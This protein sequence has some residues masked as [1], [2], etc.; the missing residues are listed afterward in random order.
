MQPASPQ[1][2]GASAGSAANPSEGAS[3]GAPAQQAS[4]GGALAASQYG[5]ARVRAGVAHVSVR[6]DGVLTA[7]IDSGVDAGHRELR[8]AIVRSVDV[9]AAAADAAGKAAGAAK[10]RAE[11][12]SPKPDAHGT[13][14]AGV[15]AARDQMRGVAPAAQILALRAFETGESGAR[16]GAY[17][18]TFAIL[19]AL[20]EAVTA[21]ARVVNMSFAGP[22]DPL[23]SK[24]LAAADAKG[25]VLVAAA[26]NGGP[27]APPAFPAA[28]A[29]VIAVVATNAGDERVASSARGAHVAIAAPG[30]DIIGPKPGD[31]Y[32]FATGSSLAA[33]HVSGVAALM[34]E[35]NPKLTPAALRKILMETAQD[36]GPAGR[37]P[38]FGAGLVDAAKAVAAGKKL[39]EAPATNSPGAGDM[40]KGEIVDVRPEP[41]PN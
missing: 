34:L 32:Q 39:A 3:Q 2:A 41:A 31:A 14:I 11:A 8:G 27:E 16:S 1:G 30:A 37:D 40:V 18:S 26:G 29:H 22:R 38:E 12:A 4:A 13:T 6:G 25:V 7:V 33:A 19:L 10:A 15:I 24:A 9:A 28:D 36:L 21:N 35:A 17:G 5:L 23:L 20:D